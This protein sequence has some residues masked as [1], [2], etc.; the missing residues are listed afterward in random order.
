MQST[1]GELKAAIRDELTAIGDLFTC[2]SDGD[3]SSAARALVEKLGSNT[4]NFVVL[5]QFKRGKTTFINALLGDKVLP[6]AVVPLTS[7]ITI[8]RHGASPK[9]TVIYRGGRS[10]M[11][12]PVSLADYV[13]ERGNPKNVKGVSHVEIEYPSDYLKDGVMLI[14]T[15]GIG[16]TF[17]H[18]TEVTYNFLS[19]VDAA[20]F[21]LSTDPPI[22]SVEMEFLEDVKKQVKKFFFVLNKADYLDTDELN[23]SIAFNREVIACAMNGSDIKIFPMSA[24]IALDAKMR[25]DAAALGMSGY[26]D[27]DRALSSFLVSEKGNLLL[28][29]VVNKALSLIESKRVSLS[30]EQ[31]SRQMSIQ[32]LDDRVSKFNA[33]LERFQRDKGSEL[34]LI[35][36]D[37]EMII[38]TLDEDLYKF[39]SEQ[40]PAV[41]KSM[42][43]FIDT[44]PK[45][46]NREFLDAVKA[47]LYK[48]VSGVCESWR[49]REESK[50]SSMYKE[51]AQVHAERMDSFVR[52]FEKTFS[53]IF[54]VSVSHYSY[55]ETPD[56]HTPI[57][58]GIETFLDEGLLLDTISTNIN[59]L[60]PSRAFRD[61]IKNDMRERSIRSIDMN[62][63]KMRYA[64]LESL[65]KS[66]GAYRS[67]YGSTAEAMVNSVRSAIGRAMAEN[68]CS[69]EEAKRRGAEIERALIALEGHKEVLVSLLERSI[70]TG[71]DE[72]VS[73]PVIAP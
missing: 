57:Y 41:L 52:H 25:G 60:L 71:A 35:D 70:K 39:K 23:D 34:H 18:N 66:A 45:S 49:A 55:E 10:E 67:S 21:M 59:L 20:V 40:E 19:K 1:Y 16:S 8:I 44:Y 3:L 30:I 29:S 11:I 12:A 7:I 28:R 27:F 72:K 38:K 53:D 31:K 58:Y 14:D 13:T 33:E 69:A 26:C 15:P 42:T 47:S 62:S 73:A 65:T 2:G 64:F 56:L 6:T 4:F 24:K 43:E 9:M 50:L 61:N 51:K 36:W 37:V 17:L 68:Q 63:G 46:G 32:A 54:D 48:V 22:S 5:G